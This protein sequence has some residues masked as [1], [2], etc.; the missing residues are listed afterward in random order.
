MTAQ[1]LQFRRAPLSRE[2]AIAIVRAAVGTERLG[3]TDHALQAL[4]DR[5]ISSRLVLRTLA[6]G[7]PRHDPVWK[8]AFSDWACVFHR[9]CSGR[10][11]KAIVGID[12]GRQ[13]VSVIT[14]Y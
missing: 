6:D 9:V 8:E 12:E 5:S 1:V 10:P 14:V 4:E 2:D 3:W 11:V 7:V 13:D